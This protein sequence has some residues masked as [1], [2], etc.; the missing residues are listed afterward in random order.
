MDRPKT[1]MGHRLNFFTQ[2]YCF[3]LISI[4]R[5]FSLSR[6]PKENCSFRN[7]CLKQTSYNISQRMYNFPEY[8]RLSIIHNNMYDFLWNLESSNDG[9]MNWIFKNI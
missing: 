3:L 9:K 2:I 4:N 5:P 1:F 6:P 7:M 8:S